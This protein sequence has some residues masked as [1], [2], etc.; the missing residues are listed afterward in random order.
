MRVPQSYET[1]R[2]FKGENREHWY[3]T[4]LLEWQTAQ[5]H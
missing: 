1:R 3:G 2:E 5:H 4:D